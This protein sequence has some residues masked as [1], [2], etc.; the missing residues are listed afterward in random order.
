MLHFYQHYYKRRPVLFQYAILVHWLILIVCL[1]S[2]CNK[3]AQVLKVSSTSK[4]FIFSFSKHLSLFLL[5]QCSS[6]W[7]FRVTLQNGI[8]QHFCVESNCWLLQHWHM[9]FCVTGLGWH[10][11]THNQVFCLFPQRKRSPVMVA[12]TDYLS[13]LGGL[14]G[15]R[16]VLFHL[17]LY[18]AKVGE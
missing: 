10:N 12:S 14:K 18:K 15:N 16:A 3:R 5:L 8:N 9:D 11:N 2:D 6:Q 1:L 4:K 17:Q 7:L 13:H